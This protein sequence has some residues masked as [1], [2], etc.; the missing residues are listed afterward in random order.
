MINLARRVPLSDLQF[1][2][3]AMLVQKET[4][5]NLAEVL[6]KTSAVLRERL[7]LQGQLRIHTAQGRVSAWILCSLPILAFLGLNI[8][9][10]GYEHTLVDDPLGRLALWLGLLGMVLGGYFIRRIVNVKV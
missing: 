1:L 2:I 3:T 6:D 8:L 4:G 9:N 7:R 10:P 5:G